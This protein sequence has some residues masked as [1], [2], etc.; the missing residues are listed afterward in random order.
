MRLAGAQVGLSLLLLVDAEDHA[1][2][3]RRPSV[4]P[5]PDLPAR[6]QPADATLRPHDAELDLVAAALPQG[7]PDRIGAGLTVLRM[8]QGLE[9]GERGDAL[10]GHAEEP[11]A[12]RREGDLPGR[13]IERPDAMSHFV[14]RLPE[15]VEHRL[16]VS[17]PCE[18][19]HIDGVRHR[20]QPE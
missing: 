10:G 6:A 15:I 7:A 9:G 19:D 16:S 11:A 18:A 4:G 12:G 17:G 5:E 14:Q 2:V 8:H 3:A 13:K 1:A 20:F